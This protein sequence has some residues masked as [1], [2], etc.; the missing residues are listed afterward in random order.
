MS[1]IAKC[2]ILAPMCA[3]RTV[4]AGL[5]VRLMPI[6]TSGE[7]TASGKAP[8]IGSPARV[9]PAGRTERSEP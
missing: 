4:E 6:Q 3:A 1:F 8:S 7:F 5:A 9:A 2:V